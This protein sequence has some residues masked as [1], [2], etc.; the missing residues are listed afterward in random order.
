MN[1]FNDFINLMELIEDLAIGNKFTWA[2]KDGSA[3]I[4]L[5]R[6]LLSSELIDESKIVGQKVGGWDILDHVSV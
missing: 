1:E 4:I 3:K 2:N 6:F 5:D